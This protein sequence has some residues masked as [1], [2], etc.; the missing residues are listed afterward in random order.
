MSAHLRSAAEAYARVLAVL[1]PEHAWRVRVGPDGP[2]AARSTPT[3][4]AVDQAGA[5]RDDA[6]PVLDRGRALRYT[7]VIAGSAGVLAGCGS[8]GTATMTPAETMNHAAARA[9]RDGSG[10][11]TANRAPAPQF[12][13]GA[14]C[15][16]YA[17]SGNVWGPNQY[18]TSCP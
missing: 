15:S 16:T 13:G 2:D 11:V 17:F 7:A 4:V 8:T 1:D 6:G 9:G 10:T 18:G 14:D 5:G 3:P 12:S